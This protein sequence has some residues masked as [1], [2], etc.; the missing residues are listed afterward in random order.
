MTPKK[1]AVVISWKD[2]PSQVHCYTDGEEEAMRTAVGVRRGTEYT[3]RHNALMPFATTLV[4]Q[5][6]SFYACTE[7]K[8]PAATNPGDKPEGEVS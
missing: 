2:G 3:R 1:Y 5:I 8:S 7:P 4:Y 6:H